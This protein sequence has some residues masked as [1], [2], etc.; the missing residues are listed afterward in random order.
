MTALAAAAATTLV[1]RMSTA[2]ANACDAPNGYVFVVRVICV[3]S[4]TWS[5]GL[6]GH[7]S[8]SM[9]MPMHVHA[10]AR[11]RGP[12]PAMFPK[13]RADVIQETP[14]DGERDRTNSFLN[15]L[16]FLLRNSAYMDHTILY[17]LY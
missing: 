11:G 8:T 10:H 6:G 4:A 15:Q 7:T 16:E 2:R 9:C 14:G 1:Q 12:P 13:F 17:D 3:C 5:A